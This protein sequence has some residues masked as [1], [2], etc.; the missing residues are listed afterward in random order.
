[1]STPLLPLTRLSLFASI[2]LLHS[3]TGKLDP[4]PFEN[5]KDP[6]P[7]VTARF[8]YE[9][10]VAGAAVGSSRRKA[11]EGFEIPDN[12][13]IIMSNITARMRA[14][15]IVAARTDKLEAKYY[16]ADPVDNRGNPY[17]VE[18]NIY[19]PDQVSSRLFSS[20]TNNFRDG[21][22]ALQP[23]FGW[24]NCTAIAIDAN[25]TGCMY[26]FGNGMVVRMKFLVVPS[27]LEDST[28]KRDVRIGVGVMVGVIGLIVFIIVAVMVSIHLKRTK[29]HVVTSKWDEKGNLIEVMTQ[30]MA[31]EKLWFSVEEIENEAL[32]S[33]DCLLAEGGFGKVYFATFSS[34]P[35]AVKY[36][37]FNDKSTGTVESFRREVSVLSAM[38]HV[39]IIN[40]MG[41]SAHAGAGYVIMELAQGSR[42]DRI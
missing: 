41:F 42:Y 30:E 24:P 28:P 26:D 9:F 15:Y 31:M 19:F 11:A 20:L 21:S 34:T 17:K 7:P 35:V 2:S 27:V 5:I 3:K 12:E 38:S 1:M 22:Y 23:K 8:W 29:G 39:N 37:L 33:E 6:G 25:T 14:A 16:S 36:V 32:L 4:L 18:T 10:D 40:L 13:R